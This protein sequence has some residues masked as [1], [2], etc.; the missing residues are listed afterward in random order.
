MTRR[1]TPYMELGQ[2]EQSTAYMQLEYQAISLRS[3]A[4]P[5]GSYEV[6]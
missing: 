2:D 3:P 4:R 5:A 6:F 1:S